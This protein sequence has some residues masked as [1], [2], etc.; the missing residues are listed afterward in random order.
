MG[1]LQAVIAECAKLGYM[2]FSHP[3]DWGFVYEVGATQGVVV[4][5]GLDKLGDRDGAPYPSPRRLV[6]PVVVSYQSGH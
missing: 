1:H 6:E 3:S 4:E 5:A 2:L